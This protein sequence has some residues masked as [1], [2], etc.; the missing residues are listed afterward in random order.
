MTLLADIRETMTSCIL[1]AR[2]DILMKIRYPADYLVGI[3]RMLLSF[4]PVLL[5]WTYLNHSFQLGSFERYTHTLNYS[6]YVYFTTVT[7]V[8]VQNFIVDASFSLSDEL[9]AGTL[10]YMFVSPIPRAAIITGTYLSSAILQGV[11]CVAL[12]TI[13]AFVL[14]L[15]ITLQET[16]LI[17][18]CLVILSVSVQ[19]IGSV[20]GTVTILKQTIYVSTTIASLI[21]FLSGIMFPV[22]VFPTAVQRISL[23]LPTTLGIDLIRSTLMRIT[24]YLPVG[25]SLLRMTAGLIVLVFAC[26]AINTV[27]LKSIFKEGKNFS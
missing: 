22:T 18:M 5:L 2:K 19:C 11:V 12:L 6:A 27:L 10:D 4:L 3:L 7:A 13:G 26:V 21:G 17:L 1:I 15:A 23:W 14:G 9:R 24:G 8:F 16:L 20:L 25:E